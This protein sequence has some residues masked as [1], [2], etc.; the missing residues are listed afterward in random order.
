MKK[1]RITV[2]ILFSVS[3]T[4]FSCINKR[5]IS[6]SLKKPDEMEN[7]RMD[8]IL[9]L[10]N[11]PE[12]SISESYICNDTFVMCY[13]EIKK[14]F[15]IA[16]N[17]RDSLIKLIEPYY[18]ILDRHSI[19][20]LNFIVF[21]EN[22]KKFMINN[23]Y[24][25]AFKYDLGEYSNLLANHLKFKKIK[26]HQ[27]IELQKKIE[28]YSNIIWDLGVAGTFEAI[29]WGLIEE[30]LPVLIVLD[31][32]NSGKRRRFLLYFDNSIVELYQL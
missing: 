14:K 7:R 13:P 2:W 30:K 9:K 12:F 24:D 29:H 32:K 28:G 23:S 19:E 4:Y 21:Y 20:D 22:L 18:N 25:S 16:K 1:I 8:S 10:S 3:L 6:C 26:T 5:N 15:E 11:L 31:E 17:Y 27:E